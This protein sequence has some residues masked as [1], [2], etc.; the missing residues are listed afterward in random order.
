MINI[1]NKT[2]ILRSRILHFLALYAISGGPKKNVKLRVLL[3]S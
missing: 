2:L 3:Y 1:Y